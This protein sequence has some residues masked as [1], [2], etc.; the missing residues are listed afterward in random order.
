MEVTQPGGSG[1]GGASLNIEVPVGTVNGVNTIFTV[2]N[3]PQAVVL[4][5]L[6]YWGGGDGYS[7]LAGTI[8]CNSDRPPVSTIR[9][10]Y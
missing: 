7:Y 1:G 9:S 10:L 4:D 6:I 2:L 8:T 3:T 5:N